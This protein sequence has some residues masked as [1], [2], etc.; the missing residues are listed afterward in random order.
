[1]EAMSMG[2]EQPRSP[3]QALHEYLTHDPE[4]FRIGSIPTEQMEAWRS[5]YGK[6]EELSPSLALIAGWMQVEAAL[7]HRGFGRQGEATHAARIT[8][9]FDDAEAAFKVARKEQGMGKYEATLALAALPM[10]RQLTRLSPKEIPDIYERWF[11]QYDEVARN[12]LRTYDQKPS[13][14]DLPFLR[15]LT[16]I[17]AMSSIYFNT[18]TPD[19]FLPPPVR[20]RGSLL[21]PET[22]S[23]LYWWN[24]NPNSVMPIRIG[25]VATE[26]TLSIE[27]SELL[28]QEYDPERGMGTLRAIVIENAGERRRRKAKAHIAVSVRPD[29]KRA[30]DHIARVSKGM[31][32]SLNEQLKVMQ[33]HGGEI[34]LAEASGNELS[35]EA[36]YDQLAPRGEP[37]F[38]NPERFDAAMSALSTEY[39]A[40][41]LEPEQMSKLAWMNVEMG[42]GLAWDGQESAMGHFEAAE[43]IFQKH[44]E[45]APVDTAAHYEARLA[46]ASATM[47]KALCIQNLEVGKDYEVAEHISWYAATLQGL[48]TEMLHYYDVLSGTNRR[49][50]QKLEPILHEL[51]A[52][53]LLIDT[54]ITTVA[55]PAAPR[56]RS[57]KGSFDM[58]VYP[59]TTDGPTSSYV[60]HMRVRPHTDTHSLNYDVLTISHEQLGQADTPQRFPTLRS[61]LMTLAGLQDADPAVDR[62]KS[63]LVSVNLTAEL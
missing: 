2:G 43:D 19:A 11:S 59:D 40:G 15:M 9:T 53:L 58:H 10:Y 61:H 14:E 13:V 54:D 46:G 57:G 52:S 41:N 32:H 56:Q 42:E 55:V 26:K 20:S 35:D 39:W 45:I 50:A 5:T 60:G 4:S 30:Q 37:Y 31:V 8:P 22:R 16:G 28:H 3:G 1:M 23:H 17:G 49:E 47:R 62:A 12:A 21:T 38:K 48:G 18:K 27:P 24:I 63:Q 34:P 36:W 25:S 51:T 7:G 33:T 6:P 29:E 44:A